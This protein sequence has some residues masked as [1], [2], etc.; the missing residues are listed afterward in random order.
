M[1]TKG[2]RDSFWIMVSEGITVHHG[3]EAIAAR[4]RNWLVIFN[5]HTGNRKGSK[6]WVGLLA[7]IA[8]LS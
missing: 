7:L 6:K 4:A 8:Y 2:R 1:A 3:G 5:T